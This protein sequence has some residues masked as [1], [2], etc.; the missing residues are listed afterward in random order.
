MY[1][2]TILRSATS[3]AALCLFAMAQLSANE[4]VAGIA[5]AYPGDKD[6]DRHPSVVFCENF[7]HDEL[8]TLSQ[9]WET[10]RDVDVMSLSGETPKASS[11]R[12]SLPT[13]RP[14]RALYSASGQEQPA[15]SF[16][17]FL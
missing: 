9:R 4:N 6:I 3:A 16:L 14:T 10:V 8:E 15:A 11:G 1:N 17:F 2:M 7:E 12:R 5:A 13:R